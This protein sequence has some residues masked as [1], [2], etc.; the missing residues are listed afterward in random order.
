MGG[1][2]GKKGISINPAALILTRLRCRTMNRERVSPSALL[3]G[4][5]AGLCVPVCTRCIASPIVKPFMAPCARTGCSVPAALPQPALPACEHT[6][7]R[8]RTEMGKG[9]GARKAGDAAK[10]SP[11]LCPSG[12]WELGD[13]TLHR[14]RAPWIS[15]PSLRVIPGFPF[16][17]LLLHSSPRSAAE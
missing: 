6:A 15:V 14:G 1:M 4:A 11:W 12:G 13:P 5:A 16:P 9:R 10:S 17:A 2:Q 3:L 7:P 8:Q